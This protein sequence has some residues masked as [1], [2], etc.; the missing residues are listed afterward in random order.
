MAQDESNALNC[1]QSL[2]FDVL[3][4]RKKKKWEKNWCKCTVPQ[5]LSSALHANLN[6]FSHCAMDLVKKEGL[7]VVWYS[8]APIQMA[9]IKLLSADVKVPASL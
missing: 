8:S 5:S 6:F 7:L 3:R 9:H 2:L 4:A 1:K